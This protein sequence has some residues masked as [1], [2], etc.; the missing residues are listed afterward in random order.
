M[1]LD[2]EKMNIWGDK[3]IYFVLL[4]TIHVTLLM[5]KC[6]FDVHLSCL[7]RIAT[8]VNMFRLIQDSSVANETKQSR[9]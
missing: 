3:K 4:F 7:N 2:L 9:V 8:D 6:C 5:L 1:R